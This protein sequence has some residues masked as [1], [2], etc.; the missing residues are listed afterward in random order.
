MDS[1]SQVKRQRRSPPAPGTPAYGQLPAV[2][3]TSVVSGLCSF[4][5]L[6][7]C[8]LS[9]SAGATVLENGSV[10]PAFNISADR[11]ALLYGVSQ[12]GFSFALAKAGLSSDA[13]AFIFVF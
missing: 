9:D 13:C 6:F 12:P 7:C 4:L 3:I 1:V 2:S 10:S 11:Y 8:A 5:Y